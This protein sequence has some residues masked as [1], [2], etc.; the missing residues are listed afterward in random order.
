MEGIVSQ[1]RTVAA[2]ADSIGLAAIQ[3]TLR[4][5]LRDLESPPKYAVAVHLRIAVFHVGIRSG[6]F[7]SLSQS[8]SPLSVPQLA[9]QT[10]T[11]TQLLER[12]ARFLASNNVIDEAGK[13]LISPAQPLKPCR[14]SS[15][16]VETGYADVTDAAKSPFQKAF[17]PDLPCFAWMAQHPEQADALQKVTK[18]WQSS[19]W[20]AE[21]ELF[22]KE[23]LNAD[24]DNEDLFYVDVGG[25]SGHQCSAVRDKYPS[26]KGQ[27]VL[28]D[29]PEVVQELSEVPGL[30]IEA[31]DILQEQQVKRAK[32]YY[33]RHVLHDFPDAQCVQILQHLRSAMTQGSRI[34]IDEVAVPEK[35][36]PWQS[37]MADLSM[38][39]LLGGRERTR[40]QWAMLTQKSS[41]QIT[42]IHEY[43]EIQVFELGHR[44]RDG[45]DQV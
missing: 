39:V 9:D 6:L 25:G 3:N 29:L 16:I 24:G 44:S 30:T 19:N 14:V 2:E 42:E 15:F 41:L 22:E 38:M 1:I 35:N 37:A 12:I 34:L 28:Q 18:S 27:L 43:N 32:F 8:Q 36:V 45:L 33:L 17:N 10:E 5:L 21:F 40:E 13:G 26:L 4:Q 20:M 7:R 23:A 31:N 11:S